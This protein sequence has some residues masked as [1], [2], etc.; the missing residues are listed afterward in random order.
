MGGSPDVIGALVNATANIGIG[1]GAAL[2]ALVLVGP[3]LG[4]LPYVGAG[5]VA[6]SLVVIVVAR[7]ASLHY[8]HATRDAVPTQPLGV[9]ARPTAARPTAAA[10]DGHYWPPF[11]LR[12]YSVGGELYG[13][14]SRVQKVYRAGPGSNGRPSARCRRAY[15]G[16]LT[17]RWIVRS[18]LCTIPWW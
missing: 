9:G 8:A 15:P 5:L 7:R 4:A 10:T 13:R 16:G 1:G 11:G 12:R 2:G 3:G 17:W 14:R 18:R 6:V